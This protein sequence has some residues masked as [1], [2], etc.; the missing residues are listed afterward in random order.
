MS[1]VAPLNLEEA[2]MEAAAA[3]PTGEAPAPAPAALVVLNGRLGGARRPLD[4]PLT[5]LG[6]AAGCDLRL[7][8]EGVR[9]LHAAVVRGPDGFCL[10][11]L[12]GGGVQVNGDAAGDCAL[13][14]GDVIALG[15]FQFRFEAGGAAA[16]RDALRA[17]AAAVAAQQAALAEEEARLALRKA[18]LEKQE[19][20]LSGHL[21][22]RRRR[23]AEVRE[24]TKQDR[25]AL[26]QQRA[27]AAKEQA[28]L[29]NRLEQALAEAAE[30]EKA[31]RA[32]RRRLVELRRRMRRRWRRHWQAHEAALRRREREG[33]EGQKQLEKEAKE[34]RRGR[35]ALAE[36]RLR[37][38]GEA[39]LGRR[40]LRDQWEELS[41]AQQQWEQCVNFEQAERER[42]ELGLKARAAAVE[43][44]ERAWADRDRRTRHAH[45][46]L[47]KEIEGLEA[48]AVNLRRRLA[49]REAGESRRNGDATPP[50]AGSTTPVVEPPVLAP[51]AEPAAS[52][53]AEAE[54]LRRTADRLADQR[55]HLLEQWG[56]LL[57]VHEAWRQ[58][59]E[60]TLA[61][62]EASNRRL[63]ERERAAEALERAAHAASAEHRQRRQELVQLRGAL[64]ARQARL[65][66]REAAWEAERETL[67][68][69]V[70]AREEAAAALARRVEGLSRRRGAQRR[71][72]AEELAAARA[73]LEDMRRQY[74]AMWQEC[75][76]RRNALANE[77]RDL[78]ARTLSLERLRLELLARAPN[79]AAAER[80]LER[81]RRR[82]YARVMAATRAAEADRQALAAEGAR[83]AEYA[84]WLQRLE[85][86]LAAGRE[87][88]A[89]ERAVCEERE[90]AAADEERRGRLELLRLQARQQ[91]GERE[92]ARLRDE[93]ERVARLLLDEAEDA[94]PPAVQAA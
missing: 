70:R 90:A 59:R 31:A 36:A 43:E 13:K 74:A 3:P 80:R 71:K 63:A 85:A 27:A 93:V 86:D 19:E 53:E 50:E 38:N 44:A 30:A 72:E 55:L 64:E 81:M 76:G 67:L 7:N 58:E 22:E 18:A 32:E 49:E 40:Q 78:A 16:E 20:Q 45:A 39:E 23:L 69:D 6:R 77:Q 48:R 66:A 14:D 8:V 83:L 65:T 24:Q 15:P 1:E 46:H 26:Q 41:L 37:F 54:A 5:L 47:L 57:E 88:L 73:R 75:Q 52:P 92:A 68:A 17:Q 51:V 34:L 10:R 11:D 82:A 29:R 94:V 2:P 4:R 33:I 9:A 60:A 56:R 61:E 87:E 12:A 35:E 89:R 62:L 79:A 28:D 25:D 21:E 91:H 84:E 42:R